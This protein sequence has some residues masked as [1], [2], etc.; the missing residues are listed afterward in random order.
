MREEDA[1]DREADDGD[2]KGE[3]P[4]A[5]EADSNPQVIYV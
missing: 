2:L 5:K 1:K 4:K 3:K